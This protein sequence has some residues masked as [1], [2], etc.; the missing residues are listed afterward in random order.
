[1]TKVTHHTLH[2]R[3]ENLRKLSE[4]LEKIPRKFGTD[5][6]ISSAEIQLIE[7]VAENEGGSVTD[8]AKLLGITKGAVSQKLKRLESRGFIVKEED[9]ANISRSVVQLTNK[10][11]TAYYAHQHWHET[12]DGG[13]K[14]Y[15]LSLE[16]DKLD[17]LDE[18]L[19]KMEEFLEKRILTEK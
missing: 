5:E 15:F 14:D 16:Q 4:K 12:M 1:M 8:L 11:K 18:A 2:A 17:F 9:P 10:G 6:N 7:V 13:F 19:G 3:F